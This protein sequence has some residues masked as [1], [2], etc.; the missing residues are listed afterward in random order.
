MPKKKKR[1]ERKKRSWDAK[2][3][4]MDRKYKIKRTEK[5]GAVKK[6]EGRNKNGGAQIRGEVLKKKWRCRRTMEKQKKRDTK[7]KDEN[8][9]NKGGGGHR[10]KKMGVQKKREG[11][12][13]K[14]GDRWLQDEK[15]MGVPKK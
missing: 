15:K 4:K 8:A 14:D 6:D 12:P 11:T 10:R 5:G 3:K 7:K 9:E 2:G 13:N 1:E